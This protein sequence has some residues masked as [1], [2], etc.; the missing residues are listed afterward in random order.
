[1]TQPFSIWK[2]RWLTV[3]L[4]A[5]DVA[6]LSLCWFGAWWIRHEAGKVEAIEPI[7][8]LT[9]YIR[10]F[11]LL[12]AVWV[13]NAAFFGLYIHRRRLT[14]LNTW[15]R[16]LMTSYQ[17]LLYAMV[18]GFLF[19]PLDLGRS[20]LFLSGLLILIYLY[21]SR[22]LLRHLKQTAVRAG[23]GTVRALIV[24]TGPLAEK[25]RTSLRQHRDI[26]F[27]LAGFVA[28][29]TEPSP[30]WAMNSDAP[31]LGT[32]TD[33]VEIVHREGIEEIF[34]A[35]G[36]LAQEVQ[37]NILNAVEVPGVPV[38]LVSN[39]FG[40]LTQG[41]NLD[42]IGELPVVPLG[43]GRL[44]W[45]QEVIKQSL[46][47]VLAALGM[48]LWLVAFH[49]WIALRI[50]LDSPGPVIFRHRRVG[51]G[52][53]IFWCYKYRTMR[54]DADPYAVAPTDPEDARVTRFGRFL[55][56]TSLDELPQLINVLRSNM[57]LV[58]P[59]P[60]MPFI[61]ENYEPWQRRRLD[62]KPGITGL[63]QVIGRKNLPLHLNMEYDLYYVRNQTL[64]LDLQ[65]LLKTIPAVFMGK[66][67][68]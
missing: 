54:T 25:I 41:A 23:R 59:R 22:T 64:L 6:G 55:R 11:P 37:L 3:L 46:D 60:E 9:P 30:D 29:P 58:G 20:V 18:L 67:A 26:G 66:G 35:I 14:S 27:E 45:H 51:R 48:V 36:H 5:A 68:F 57:S 44:P 32:T 13:G 63:W 62:V 4:V 28:H 31:L 42:E 61:V 33:M 8:V 53:K 39:I 38:H 1:M 40:V 49:W 15:R 21:V 52:G 34:L 10:I 2:S 12:L 24:G 47:L 65:I 16:I 19:K 43:T 50:K 17:C 7:N 56:R